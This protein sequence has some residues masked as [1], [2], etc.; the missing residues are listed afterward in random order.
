MSRFSI[1]WIL[2]N[3]IVTSSMIE[4]VIVTE[5]EMRTQLKSNSGQ[6]MISLRICKNILGPK[7]MAKRIR[8]R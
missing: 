1:K 3:K 6:K 5:K 4:R 7:F 8:S 2:V